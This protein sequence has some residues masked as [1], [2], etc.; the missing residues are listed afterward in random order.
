MKIHFSLSYLLLFTLSTFQLQAQNYQSAESVEYDPI[1]KQWLA[2][3][4]NN[5]IANDGYGNLS[6]FGNGSAT[7]GLEVMDEVLFAIDGS[8]LRAFNLN[9]E[10]EISSVTITGA[11][12]LNGIT[13]DGVSNIYITDFS[14][15]K[16]Y[17][18]DVSDL[19]N[20]TFEIIVNNT[21][22][23]PNGI[24]YNG[25]NNRLIFVSWGSSAAIKAVDLNNNDVSTILTTNLGNIDGI[26]DDNDGNYYI[27]SWSPTRISK[28]DKDF[29]NPPETISTPFINNPADIGYSKEADTLAIPIANNVVFVGF[30]NDTTVS[31]QILQNE[32]FS[33]TVFPNPVTDQS[34]VEFELENNQELNLQI[35]DNQGKLVKTLLTGLQPFGKHKVLLAGLGLPSGIYHLNLQT[36]AATVTKKLIIP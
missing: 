7:H 13:N 19:Q 9:T 4:G 21:G 29:A 11:S 22:S 35:F 1:N 6:F 25:E 12:F 31:V 32:E 24:I 27:S 18:V 10:D 14:A 20:M 2:S 33:L 16:I 5:I 17:R 28:Y 3:N 8:V 34:Y 23:T 36:S 30:E 26:D 15:K